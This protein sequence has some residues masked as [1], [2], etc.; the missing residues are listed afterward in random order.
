LKY[1]YDLIFSWSQIRLFVYSLAHEFNKF[2]VRFTQHLFPNAGYFIVES[3]SF[4]TRL[5]YQLCL[6]NRLPANQ[7]FLA[8]KDFQ[9]V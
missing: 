9:V 1:F 7:S 8:Q 6:L 5:Q 4:K 3:G 2:I